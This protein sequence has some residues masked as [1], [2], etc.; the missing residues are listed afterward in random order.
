MERTSYVL[1]LKDVS[2]SFSGIKVL[3]NVGFQL[4]FREVHALMGENGAG[5]STLM[6]IVMGIYKADEGDI[7][8]RGEQVNI[9]DTSDALS[10]GISMIHQELSPI[11]EMTVAE[12]IFIGRESSRLGVFVNKREMNRRAEQ[13]LEEYNMSG[14]IRP[15]MKMKEL[16]IAQVQMIE[17]IK[18]VSYDS[19]I[20][21]M[22]EPTSSLSDKESAELFKII[23]QLRDNNVGIIYIS[24]RMEEVFQLADRVSVLRDGRFIGCKEVAETTQDQLVSMMV[25]RELD[26][27]YPKNA[28]EKGDIAKKYHQDN[29]RQSEKKEVPAP[30]WFHHFLHSRVS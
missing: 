28:A 15:G 24:H 23:G 10:M 11:P 29:K 17:I 4:R 7:F 30:L 9:K 27:V 21:I 3:S 13:L 20:I 26:S 12:N 18:A 22:D 5:K 16:S 6:K 2:K 8:L 14:D 1:E 25:G 19:G